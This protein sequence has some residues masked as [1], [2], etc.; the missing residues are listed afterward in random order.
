MIDF[1]LPIHIILLIIDFKGWLRIFKFQLALIV[2]I[3]LAHDLAHLPTVFFLV[4]LA[5]HLEHRS[6]RDVFGRQHDLA[7]RLPA[8]VGVLTPRHFRWL[9]NVQSVCFLLAFALDFAQI[10]VVVR[11]HG[12]IKVRTLIII[13]QPEIIILNGIKLVEIRIEGIHYDLTLPVLHGILRQRLHI[14]V[15]VVFWRPAVLE[16]S[17][18]Y[19]FTCWTHAN[20]GPFEPQLVLVGAINGYTRVDFVA[21]VRAVIRIQ[22]ASRAF[23]FFVFI[24]GQVVLFFLLKQVLF[25]VV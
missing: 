5:L 18:D 12:V 6:L 15:P 8:E 2:G 9:Q 7:I 19:F 22:R 24:Y 4:A 23:F 21:G 3:W 25:H 14:R 16:P 13:F 17:P 11:H 20:S 1:L 10:R